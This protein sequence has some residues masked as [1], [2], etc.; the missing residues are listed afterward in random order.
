[1]QGF[2]D[3]NL[4]VPGTTPVAQRR[5]FPAF[6]T[7]NSLATRFNSSYNA[8]QVTFDRRFGA[9]LQFQGS[10]VYSHMI[11]DIGATDANSSPSMVYNSR[12]YRGNSDLNVPHRVVASWL[13]QLPIKFEGWK[14]TAFGGWQING[15][16]TLSDGLPFD[17][18]SPNTTNCCN[19]RP[20]RIGNGS[21]PD[22]ERSINRWF[23]TS[24]FREPGFL[25][26]GNAGRNILQGPGTKQIDFSTFK[27]FRFAE[28]R[29]LEF[30]GELFN[31]L[32]TPQFN[33]PN[34]AVGSP[35]FGRIT[36]AGSPISL[37]RTSRQV[38]F[39]LK[40]YF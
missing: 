18:S 10:Y 31:V 25:Q 15:I 20:D 19:S 24:A 26:F 23:D 39:G 1:L 6:T 16:L 37:Q 40:L 11:D 14:E 4:P 33:N 21:L 22:D 13:Y 32:N 7:V 2:P 9:G 34:G 35:A 38:Q 12:L 29:W 28:T 3:I 36:S 8:F 30:R 27:K 17:L 5:P